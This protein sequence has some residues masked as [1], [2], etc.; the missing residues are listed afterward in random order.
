MSTAP[1]AKDE[2]AVTCLVRVRD[3]R[4]TFYD[5]LAENWD[6]LHTSHPIESVFA[7]V[8]HRAVRTKA[9]ARHRPA[10][11]VQAGQPRRKLGVGSKARNSCPRSSGVSRSPIGV[12]VTRQCR[13][14]PDHGVTQIPA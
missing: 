5:F 1:A 14:P 6:H 3:M 11:G 4:L 10:H 2:K 8:R 7:T 12:A 13:A 9:V